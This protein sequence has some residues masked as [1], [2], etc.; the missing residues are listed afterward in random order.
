M[1]SCKKSFTDVNQGYE[2]VV[3]DKSLEYA[4]KKMT[5]YW[6]LGLFLFLFFTLRKSRRVY[7]RN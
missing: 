1:L 4:Q 6:V 5:I 2:R 7:E 3:F